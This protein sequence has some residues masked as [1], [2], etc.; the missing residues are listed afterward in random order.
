MPN[1]LFT[2]KAGEFEGPLEHLLTLIEERKFHINDISLAS[3]TDEYLSWSKSVPE[4]SMGDTAQFV[5]VAATLLLI[6]SKSLLP[7]LTLT[8]DEQADIS[9]LEE[10][11]RMY[12]RIRGLTKHLKERFGVAPIIFEVERNPSP[13][14]TPDSSVTLASILLSVRT[15]ISAIPLKE[16][17]PI[18]VIEKVITLEEMI[19][20][21][22]S[23]IEKSL[24]LT[25]KE[26]TK[27]TKE[28]K[29]VIVGFLALLELVKRGVLSAGQRE[30]FEDIRIESDKPGVPS[31]T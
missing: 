7:Q 14:F 24:S 12:Q 30:R 3:V 20:R 17:I 28:K 23:R 29:E 13:V 4:R 1:E 9:D 10:R 18:K 6:K 15:A 21:L 27:G 25:F 16:I 5:V 8:E 11:L 26:F 31:Y 22:A 2:V 19:V